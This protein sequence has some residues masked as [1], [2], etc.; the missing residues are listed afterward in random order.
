M[1][2]S[3]STSSSQMMVVYHCGNHIPDVIIVSE[4]CKLSKSKDEIEKIETLMHKSLSDFSTNINVLVKSKM[5][6]PEVVETQDDVSLQ[7]LAAVAFADYIS[8]EP[9]IATEAYNALQAAL[10]ITLLASSPSRKRIT[11]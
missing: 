1:S 7:C 9:A 4:E 5:T 11:I 3:N 2:V 10:G 6:L 8:S